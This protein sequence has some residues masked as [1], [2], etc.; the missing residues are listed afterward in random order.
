[1]LP[2]GAGLS[3]PFPP[4]GTH[5]SSCLRGGSLQIERR[6]RRP[7]SEEECSA[8][9]L[10]GVYFIECLFHSV[11]HATQGRY[12][13]MHSAPLLFSPSASV[14]SV[15]AESVSFASLCRCVI[16]PVRHGKQHLCMFINTA[17]PL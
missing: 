10:R 15:C 14:N 5:T 1:M 12:G 11:K 6:L 7:S 13:A 3:C 16:H 8:V 17:Q 9:Q 4:A 2:H